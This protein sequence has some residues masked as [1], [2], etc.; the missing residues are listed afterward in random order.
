MWALFGV[1]IRRLLTDPRKQRAPRQLELR[2][3][4]DS[5]CD[6]PLAKRQSKVHFTAVPRQLEVAATGFLAR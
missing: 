4:F 2:E 5:R 6:W 3:N 1:A